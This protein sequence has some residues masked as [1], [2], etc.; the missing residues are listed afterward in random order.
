MSDLP[1]DRLTIAPPFT[2]VGLDVFGPW[3][4]SSCRTRSGHVENKRWAVMFT[5][6]STGAVHIKVIEKMSTS[7]VINALRRFTAIRGPVRLLCSDR[8]INYQGLQITPDKLRR[9][10]GKGASARQKLHR[11]IDVAHRILDAMLLKENCCL[12]HEML[13]TLMAEVMAIMNAQ[14]L[15]PA[16]SDP[17]MPAVFTPAMLLTQKMDPASAPLGNMDLKDFYNKQWMQVQS[18]A[19]IFWRHW[20]QEY[21]VTLQPGRKWRSKKPNLEIGDVVLLKDS[22][23][24]RNEWPAGVIEDTIPSHDGCIRKVN[25]KTVRQGTPKVFS[26]PVSDAVFYPTFCVALEP[27]S[28]VKICCF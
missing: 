24:K 20:K 11:M 17:E 18:L 23:V 27:P 10:R 21:L 9:P 2:H 3:T 14:F 12:T 8:G 7:S 4:I 22:Q 19:E 26:R 25:V 6:L 15:V 28:G 5:C 1:V 16:S 13:V